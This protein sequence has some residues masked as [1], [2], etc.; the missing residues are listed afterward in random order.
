MLGCT[1]RF[2]CCDEVSCFPEIVKESRRQGARPGRSAS[3][4][5]SQWTWAQESAWALVFLTKESKS[6]E[7][8]FNLFLSLNLYYFLLK[9][10]I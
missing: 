8:L 6:K 4:N 9:L 7:I 5:R 1:L 3:L 2:A 10:S